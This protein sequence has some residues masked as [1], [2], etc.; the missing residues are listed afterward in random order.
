MTP[1]GIEI[2]DPETGAPAPPKSFR[3]AEVLGQSLARALIAAWSL[4]ADDPD[5]PQEHMSRGALAV[6][7]KVLRVPLANR[8]FIEGLTRGRIWPRAMDA[9]GALT[10]EVAMVTL[11]GGPEGEAVAQFACVPGEIY[12]ELVNG[13]IQIPQDPG[14][15]LQGELPEPALRT[16]MSGRFRFVIGVCNDELGYIIPISQWDEK[17]PFAYGRDGP[18]YG[19]GNSAGPQT[20]PILVEAFADI[21]R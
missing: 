16:M 15:D 4:R 9:D 7:R 19:E 14:A 13:G 17:P 18:Q 1:L 8:R 10:S 20:A 11:R 3:M 12:P 2:E 5:A 21:L 6:R